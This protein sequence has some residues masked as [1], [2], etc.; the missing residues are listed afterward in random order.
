MH[1]PTSLMGT[2]KTLAPNASLVWSLLLLL[3]LLQEMQLTFSFENDV[4]HIGTEG[5]LNG[6]I[7]GVKVFDFRLLDNQSYKDSVFG[8]FCFDIVASTRC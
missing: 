6:T 1:S 3:L 4:H 8:R 7:V 5:V 2:H